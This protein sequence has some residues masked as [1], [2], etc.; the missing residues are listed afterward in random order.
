M[1]N[2]LINPPI[3]SIWT[4][5]VVGFGRRRGARGPTLSGE[6]ERERDRTC[7]D[8]ARGRRCWARGRRHG[9]RPAQRRQRWASETAALGSGTAALGSGTAAWRAP[10]SETAA[11]GLGE[12]G[13]GQYQPGSAVSA[14]G[15][16]YGSYWI[17]T[18]RVEAFILYTH[19]RRMFRKNACDV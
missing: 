5:Q 14:P 7:R 8:W 19:H 2:E 15:E 10:S 4:P 1:K 6:R 9:G 12:D 13:V 17:T 16:S 3:A 18:H 11:L